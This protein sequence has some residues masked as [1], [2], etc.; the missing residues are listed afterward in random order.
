[1]PVARLPTATI[2][3]GSSPWWRQPHDL[4]RPPSRTRP[5]RRGPRAGTWRAPACATVTRAQPAGV[6]ASHI[7]FRSALPDKCAL[8]MIARPAARWDRGRRRPQRPSPR[9]NARHRVHPLHDRR[10]AAGD[11]ALRGLPASVRGPRDAPDSASYARRWL[12]AGAVG[13]L[14]SLCATRRT[15]SPRAAAVQRTPSQG[16][17]N[18]SA[19]RTLDT[20][21][22][23]R[24][25]ACSCARTA[26]PDRRFGGREG[27]SPKKPT[28]VAISAR[29]TKPIERTSVLQWESP[30]VPQHQTAV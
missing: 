27:P 1:M 25:R 14:P 8:C 11:N 28:T 15:W 5:T 4:P 7:R 13:T 19:M 20:T 6:F 18:T 10:A 17:R 9:S 29:L 30:Y 22:I 3:R 2:P 12:A 23:A 24:I 21:A 26:H 16:A